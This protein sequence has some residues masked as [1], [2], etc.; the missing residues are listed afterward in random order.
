V[1]VPSIRGVVMASALALALALAWSGGLQ[2][3]Q[4]KKVPAPAPKPPAA[5]PQAGNKAGAPKPVP[6]EALERF[7]N[8]SP[9][10]RQKALSKL[11]PQ[12]Q[13]QLQTRLDN[14]DRMSPAQRAQQLERARQLEKLTPQRQKAVTS[15]IQGMTGLSV[16]D[17]REYLNGPEFGKK[18]SPEEQQIVRDRFP[19]ATSNVVKPT[20]KLVPA[21][22][23]AVQQETQRIRAMPL[24]ERREALHSPEFSQQYSPEEQQ[25]IRDNFPNAAK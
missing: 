10:E 12:Q 17:Q 8:M 11:P 23:Q 20:D 6:T 24:A 25:I 4:A 7:L 14:L 19:P 9:E 13:K 15:Q 1:R 18:F 22:R 16:A 2:G 5:K 21:R 3:G